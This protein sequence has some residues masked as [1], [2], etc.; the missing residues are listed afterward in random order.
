MK[1]QIGERVNC[2]SNAKGFQT[3]GHAIKL[4]SDSYEFTS[5][6]GETRTLKPCQLRIVAKEVK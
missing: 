1:I 6:K 2:A 5:D 3:W 4:S